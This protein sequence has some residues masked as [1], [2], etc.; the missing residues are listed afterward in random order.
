MD[1]SLDLDGS[2]EDR[3]A[4][5]DDWMDV[6]PSD[7]E[8]EAL[9]DDL[10]AS[11]QRPALLASD[12]ASWACQFQV[13]HN[14]VDDLLKILRGHGHTDL[15]STTRTLL[16][17][18]REVR[19]TSKSATLEVLLRKLETVEQNQREALLLL[20]ANRRGDPGEATVELRQ[21][22]TQAEL[23]ELEEQLANSDFTKKMISHLSLVG[24]SNPGECV[25]RVLRSVASNYVWS[26][27]SLRGK[28]GKMPL[29]GTAVGSTVKQAIMKWKPGLEEK[30]VELLI[31]EVLKHS[32][33]AHSKSLKT[34]AQTL[35]SLYCL[36]W[37]LE[38]IQG[39]L[40][41]AHWPHP[42][43]FIQNVHHPGA[44]G[45]LE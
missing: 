44:V 26:S 5:E 6:D 11:D 19:I 38:D 2:F 33:S 21:A 45:Y 16:K 17:T 40:L 32:P 31:A 24:G 29:L 36:Q 23:N 27:Y 12:L 22:Q 10:E 28:K 4:L 15:P 37:L 3:S 25:R 1:N 14:A 39:I 30:E 9:G 20:R 41:Y 18:P 43:T 8:E 42:S 35:Q 7:E 13:K 34:V